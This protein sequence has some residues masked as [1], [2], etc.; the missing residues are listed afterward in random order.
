MIHPDSPVSMSY[1]EWLGASPLEEYNVCGECKHCKL[2]S[3]Y[4]VIK[5]YVCDLADE[6][7]LGESCINTDYEACDDFERDAKGVE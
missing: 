4:G 2:S 6:T 3:E 5:N 1:D 7:G